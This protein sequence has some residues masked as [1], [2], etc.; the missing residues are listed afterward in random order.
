MIS[1]KNIAVISKFET[2]ILWRNWFFKIFA[3]LA[4]FILSIFNLVAFTPLTDP[5]WFFIANSW[6]IPYANMLLL[7]IGQAAA[8]IFLAAGSISKNKKIDTNEVFFVRSLSN[9]DYVLGKA[10]AIF[11]LFFW[12]NLAV[13]IPGIIMNLT[14]PVAGFNFMAY[15][16][17]PLLVSIP[18]IIFL[19]GLAFFTATVLRN[20][21]VTIIMLLGLSA[22]VIFYFLNQYDNILDFMAFRLNMMASE[23]A[24]F[25]KLDFILMQR[26]FYVVSGIAFLFAAAFFLNRLANH[27]RNK[28]ALSV[29]IVL[30]AST[31]TWLMVNMWQMR[32]RTISIRQELIEMNGEWSEKANVEVTENHISITHMGNI[33]QG[34]SNLK[35]INRREQSL[36]TI[37][38]TLNPALKVS[39]VKI[40]EKVVVFDQQLQILNIPLNFNISKEQ[41]VDVSIQY[42]GQI[43]EAVAHLEVTQKRYEERDQSFIYPI[44]KRYAFLQP[45]YVLLTKDVLWYP[46]TQIGYSKKSPIRERATLIDFKLDVKT[47]GDLTAISQGKSSQN[48][49]QFFE[50][51]PEY[52]LPQISL[53]IGKYIKKSVTVDSI[54]YELYH[55]PQNDYFS[56]FFNEVGDTLSYLIKDLKNGYEDDQKLNYPFRR[57]QLVESPIQFS[58]YDKIY[59]SHQSYVQPEIILL[60]ENG[61]ESR[62]FDLKR[63]FRY[64]DEQAKREN[65]V[66]SDKEKQANVFNTIV[67]REFTR[68]IAN[69]FFLDGRNT[70]NANYSIFPN[71]YDY[72]SG[73]VS[74]DWPTINRSLASYLNNEKRPENDYSRNING[75]SFAEECNELMNRNSLMEILTSDEEF[76][77]IKKSISLKGE[78]LFS[79][80]EQ[81]LG[82]TRF[83][84]FM[85]LWI[86][87]NQHS[88]NS[89]NDLRNAI[90]AEFQTD[91]DQVIKQIYSDQD[92][93][94]FKIDN[95]RK[96]EILDGDRKRYQLFVDVRNTGSN[97]GVVK[98]K[99][100]DVDNEN[101][102]SFRRNNEV[103]AVTFPEYLSVVKKGEKLQLGFLLDSKPSQI[104][105][106]TLVSQNIPS[107]VNLTVGQF[108]PN[109][110]ITPFEGERKIL[111]EQ[112]TDQYQVI[113]DNEDPGFTTFSP[114]KDTYLKEYLDSKN[115]SEKKYYGIWR[116]SF[117][118][119]LPTTGANYYGQHIRSAHFTRAGTGEKTATWKPTLKEEGFYDIYVFMKGKNQ[120]ESSNNSS[121]RKY[122]YQ[123]TINHADGKDDI[124]F[125]LA[126]ADRGWNYLGSYY[127]TKDG[128][129]VELTDRCEQR[130]VY[131]DAVKWVK[132]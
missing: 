60:P 89:Y 91:I 33:I 19:I 17:Y 7:G 76:D 123:Y 114:I 3:I 71:L 102:F 52:P 78:Y 86:N 39:E 31:A 5:Q 13:L 4:I 81:Q 65:K 88:R 15:I 36:D 130:R 131:A 11:K 46:D 2:K 83:K 1:L 56:S 79:I 37:F 28:I 93:P 108:K 62:T 101:R 44:G 75:I 129:S 12:L 45:D 30:F 18:T 104:S 84:D 74:N 23:L 96:F 8:I 118:K 51:R 85:Y 115:P 100:D 24:G 132:Q 59:E 53:A 87:R 112:L 9:T 80:L 120:G 107:V 117:S 42:E 116:G 26:G 119:W 90:L 122:S 50:F 38:F 16:C 126:N 99:F 127:L 49:E 21:P 6:N 68:Q 47:Q 64:M 82:N 113:V 58:A 14:N 103:S 27:K 43:D 124:N 110:K 92:Q 128:S 66:M 40:D 111:D 41:I 29:V 94:A 98:V 32:N 67:K 95:L 77:K 69:R 20:Q 61:G 10:I 48:K 73:I 105:V 22:L 70:D 54:D 63:Q 25:G 109:N 125:N 106:N 97:D 121:G 57:L 72:N 35:A 34:L 55:Y